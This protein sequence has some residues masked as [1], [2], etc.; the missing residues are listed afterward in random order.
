MAERIIKVVGEG[1]TIVAPDMTR[2]TIKVKKVFDTINEAYNE[3]SRNINTLRYVLEEN[4][5]TSNDLT[6]TRFHVEEH[7]RNYCDDKDGAI[8]KVRD[9]FRMEQDFEIILG[10]D[11]GKV[12]Q[13]VQA[14]GRELEDVEIGISRDCGHIDHFVKTMLSEAVKNAKDKA[15]LLAKTIDCEIIEVREIDYSCHDYHVITSPY[16]FHS[17]DEALCCDET[18]LETVLDD[19]S[20]EDHVVVHCSFDESYT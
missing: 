7:Y 14:I 20:I 19:L 17:S 16:V 9:G 5:M 6:P 18:V 10:I 2:L 8:G 12:S 3:S 15:T 4:G 1:K 11:N 13:V